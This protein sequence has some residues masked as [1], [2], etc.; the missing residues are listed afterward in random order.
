MWTLSPRHDSCLQEAPVAQAPALRRSKASMSM[1][2]R[3]RALRM[4]SSTSARCYRAGTCQG[5]NRA[6]AHVQSPKS[7][8]APV[9]PLLLLP[10][11][12]PR[13]VAHSN[14]QKITRKV[15]TPTLITT[16]TITITSSNTSS[17][18]AA[19]ALQRL[20][21]C[22][23]TAP[24]SR[25]R[26]NPSASAGAVQ[27]QRH[28]H[29]TSTPPPPPL[30]PLLLLRERLVHR[31]HCETQSTNR[32]ASLRLHRHPARQQQRH[33]RRHPQRHP[34]WQC[35]CH[36][37]DSAAA[38]A[39]VIAAMASLPHLPASRAAALHCMHQ[40]RPRLPHLLHHASTVA[41]CHRHRRMR[42]HLPAPTAAP[43]TCLATAARALTCAA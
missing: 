38:A 20:S 8:R 1:S 41:T 4:S 28:R 11:P 34:R 14:D 33:R 23:T 26:W 21:T 7:H 10:P 5:S 24:N 9:P 13:P 18:V 19:L 30:P 3:N 27:S 40:H 12:S 31:H 22:T 32:G 15:L 16:A 39:A 42:R 36:D 37:G 43:V 17:N 29:H 35:G 25:P 6:L 2:R